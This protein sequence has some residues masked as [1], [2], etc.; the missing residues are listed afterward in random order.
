MK[1]KSFKLLL[2]AAVSSS[3][4]CANK[5]HTTCSVDKQYMQE[6]YSLFDQIMRI[7]GTRKTL[8]QEMQ[9]T[10]RAFGE[11]K[12]SAAE[13]ARLSHH[14]LTTENSLATQVT[15]LYTVTRDKGCFDE[16]TSEHFGR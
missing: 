5:H 12:V 2:M 13:H 4:G 16:I 9:E 10:T 8:S 3:T 1:H 7:Q 14:W 6:C 11:G 15:R